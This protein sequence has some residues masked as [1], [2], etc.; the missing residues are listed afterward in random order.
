MPGEND[1][2]TGQGTPDAAGQG[3]GAGAGSGAVQLSQ[4]EI[5]ARIDK[6]VSA[7]LAKNQKTIEGYISTIEG[8][9]REKEEAGK[10]QG[11]LVISLRDQM[12]ELKTQL[13]DKEKAIEGLQT[14]FGTMLAGR[15]EALGAEAKATFEKICPQNL[16]DQGKLEFLTNLETTGVVAQA[17]P[18][19]E[20]DGDG[21]GD[22]NGKGNPPPEGPAGNP[23]PDRQG[24]PESDKTSDFGA[25]MAKK[26]AQD[27]AE[28]KQ[29]AS[30]PWAESSQA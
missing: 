6:A 4:Q 25:E 13:K 20:G 17:T 26:A 23:P 14:T 19:P 28:R 1:Q 18:N 21:D 24:E 15:L 9:E 27:N 10:S 8:L 29:G 3:A 7:A 16:D 2:G 12:K 11:E 5:Q 22:G 30:D